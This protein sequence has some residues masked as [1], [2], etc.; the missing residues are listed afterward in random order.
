MMASKGGVI[1]IVFIIFG[2]LEIEKHTNLLT[3]ML[4][5]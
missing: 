5:N 4:I 1:R 3:H 2:L